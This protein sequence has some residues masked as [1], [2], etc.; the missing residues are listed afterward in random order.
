M[1]QIRMKVGGSIFPFTEKLANH[2]E[3][4]VIEVTAG[5][6][7]IVDVSEWRDNV[8]ATVEAV[9]VEEAPQIADYVAEAPLEETAIP[10]AP[11][12]EL[13]NVDVDDL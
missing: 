9:E 5:G 12:D 8:V 11:D 3:A 7:R 4:E 1:Y 6:T 13:E 10:V 2:S